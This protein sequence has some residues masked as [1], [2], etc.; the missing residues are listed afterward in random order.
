[1]SEARRFVVQRHRARRLHYDFR[2]ELDGVLVSWAVPKGPTLDPK[3]RRGAYHV[4]DHALDHAG[5]EGRIPAGKY[6]RGDVIVW[7]NGTWEPREGDD[8]AAALAAG[9]LHFDVYGVKL[10]GRF[11]LKRTSGD[12]WLLLHKGDEH[13]VPGWDAEDHPLSVLSGRTNDEV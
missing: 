5:F 8:P 13:A 7:D 11:V 6:G 1:M 4:E 3:A 9:E 2:L 10:H 12:D